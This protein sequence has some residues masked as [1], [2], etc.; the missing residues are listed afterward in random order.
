MLKYRWNFH[1]DMMSALPRFAITGFDHA[2]F[3]LKG[4]HMYGKNFKGA[5]GMVGYTPIQTPLH[6]EQIGNGGLKN[7]SMLF[8]HYNPTRHT[9]TIYF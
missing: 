3:L 8:I 7:K 6:F 5:A 2:Y 9:E 4:I 1:A